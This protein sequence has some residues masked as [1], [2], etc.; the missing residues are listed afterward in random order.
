MGQDAGKERE[1]CYLSGQSGTDTHQGRS[2]FK[3]TR[4]VK[5]VEQ[6]KI[7]MDLS[8]GKKKTLKLPDHSRTVT[9]GLSYL[10]S[11]GLLCDVSIVSC[12]ESGASNTLPL[13]CHKV[14]LASASTFFRQ[15]F[16]ESEE[17]VINT[18]Y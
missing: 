16:V 4:N 17:K 18:S 13:R 12:E 6:L 14:V 3:E 11:A 9:S 5:P 15:L 8:V 1:R 2:G 7:E 10:Q